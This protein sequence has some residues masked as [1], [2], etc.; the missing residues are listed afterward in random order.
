METPLSA[1]S[2]AR[3]LL[4][5]MANVQSRLEVMKLLQKYALP[6][7]EAIDEAVYDSRRVLRPLSKEAHEELTW[8]RQELEGEMYGRPESE[9]KVYKR[10]IYKLDRRLTQMDE[11][12]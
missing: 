5:N 4:A 3:G 1:L 12:Q 8:W 6:C 7:I 2:K 9:Q 10:L 11:W